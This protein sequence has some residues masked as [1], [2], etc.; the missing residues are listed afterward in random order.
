MDDLSAHQLPQLLT[1]AELAERW[2]CSTGWLA[3][4]RSA[5]VG[6]RFLKLGSNV[7]YR[8]PDVIAYE[9]SCSTAV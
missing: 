2:G 9:D 5:G 8:V 7:R 4:M 1:S 3:N 6:P